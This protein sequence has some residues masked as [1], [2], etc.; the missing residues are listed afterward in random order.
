MDAVEYL[1]GYG[2]CGDFGRFRAAA[3]LSCRRGARV[4]VNTPRGVEVGTV[5]REATPRHAH[6]LPNTTVGALLRPCTPDDETALDRLRDRG[7]ELFE[8]ARA[9][10]AELA[11]P[12]EPIDVEV[13]LDG[14]HAVL[15]H[16]RFADCDVRPLVS[17]LSR[18]F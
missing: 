18:E 14:T 7:Q 8:R 6:F 5:L 9:L 13:L 11:L 1:V 12:L 3:T 16:L 4:V 10:A 15:H 17:T 2:Q